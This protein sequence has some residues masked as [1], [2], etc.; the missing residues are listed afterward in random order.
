MLYYSVGFFYLLLQIVRGVRDILEQILPKAPNL[1]QR[2]T[3]LYRLDFR[4]AT[5]RAP[6]RAA[7][8][9]KSKMATIRVRCHLQFNI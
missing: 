6:H 7:T 2:S 3:M 1:A 4:R 8:L 9:A 5:K